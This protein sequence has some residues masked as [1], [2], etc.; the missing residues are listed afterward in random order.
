M[1]LV[2]KDFNRWCMLEMFLRVIIILFD[3]L[4]F[5]LYIVCIFEKILLLEERWCMELYEFCN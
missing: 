4:L 1:F 2:F 5:Y 3:F